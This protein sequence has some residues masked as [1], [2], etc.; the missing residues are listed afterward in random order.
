MRM[1]G[2]GTD[3]K[4]RDASFTVEI[5]QAQLMKVTE[6]LGNTKQKTAWDRK[7]KYYEVKEGDVTINFFSDYLV[8]R[9]KVRGRT[10]EFPMEAN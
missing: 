5:T 6:M 9:V 8:L 10:A 1:D 3:F 2:A 7:T 4:T